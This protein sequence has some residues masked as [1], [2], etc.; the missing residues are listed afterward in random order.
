MKRVLITGCGGFIGSHLADFLITKDLSTYGMVH[1]ETRN[2]DHLRNKMTVLNGD[3][4]NK[5]EVEQVVSEI[6]PDIVFHLAAQSF[7]T[8]SWEEPEETLRVNVLGTFYLL[9]SISKLKIVPIIEVIGSSAVYGAWDAQEMP[10][11]EDKE[12]RPTSIYAVSKTAQDMLAYFYWRACKMKIIRIRPFNITGPRKTFDA[13]SDFAKSVTEVERKLKEVVEV[14]NLDTVR[15]FTDVRDA[16]K[17]L[18]LLADKGE[19][20]QTYNVC[21]GK[22]YKMEE[23]LKQLISLSDCD[24]KYRVV[25]EKVRPFDDPIIV[26]DNTKLRSLGWEPQVPLEK[27][28][29]DMLDYW[30]RG[31]DR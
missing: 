13:C 22:G 7:V 4:T 15:D 28:L 14:G 29:T 19:Y 11:S 8:T 6:Q 27:T 12:F 26:G 5:E 9:D 23:I 18:W 16:V 1:G 3:L 31:L 2:V 20:G 25:P 10:L 30:R 21:S 24:I 17:A